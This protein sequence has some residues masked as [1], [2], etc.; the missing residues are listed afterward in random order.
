MKLIDTTGLLKLLGLQ[1]EFNKLWLF[2]ENDYKELKQI[3][4]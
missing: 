1:N 4:I 2:N 3:K